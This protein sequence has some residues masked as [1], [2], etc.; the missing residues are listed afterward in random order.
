[1]FAASQSAICPSRQKTIE[2]VCPVCEQAF[3]VRRDRRLQKYCSN[4]CKMVGVNQTRRKRTKQMITKNCKVCDEVF[5]IPA[6]LS[7]T[8]TCSRKCG[9]IIRRKIFSRQC[10][11]CKTSF[12][13]HPSEDK[14][15]CSITC[16]AL[17]RSGEG[18]HRWIKERIK[19]CLQCGKQ[20]DGAAGWRK[21]KKFCSR[22][23]NYAYSN[24]HGGP[25]AFPIGTV[26]QDPDGYRRVKVSLKQ[27]RPEHILVVEKALGRKLTRAEIVHHRNGKHGDNRIDNLQVVT[28]PQHMRIHH[29]AEQIGLLVMCGELQVVEDKVH[30]LEGCEV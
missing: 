25:T 18:H 4:R 26:V 17:F 30:P 23:C 14:K 2:K 15:T 11:I 22:A 10:A 29:E 7:R 13:T 19:V 8:D 6:Y 3:F 24:E 27:W 16:A 21:I 12:M 9:G 5:S 28:R 20:Y 1:M